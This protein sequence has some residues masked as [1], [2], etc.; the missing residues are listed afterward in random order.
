M[1][2]S[3]KAAAARRNALGD[4]GEDR[5]LQ[6]LQREGFVVEKMPK[7]FPFFDLMAKKG[8]R[9]VLVPVKAR[10]KFTAKGKIKKNTYNLYTKKGHLES[11]EK[12]ANFFGADLSWIA[13]TVDTK[14]KTYSAYMGDL[15]ELPERKGRKYIPMHPD[16]DVPN[17]RSL[18]IDEPDN[19]IQESWSNIVEATDR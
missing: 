12:I 15:R 11:A 1:N 19:A 3:G 2:A 17:H 13:V 8:D 7:N 9:K 16:R 6:L 18:V 14:A 4:F 10:N 5:A